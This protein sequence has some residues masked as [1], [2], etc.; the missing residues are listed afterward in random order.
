MELS[1][2]PAQWGVGQVGGC[3]SLASPQWRA[4]SPHSPGGPDFYTS[5]VSCVSKA[6]KNYPVPQYI[7]QQLSPLFTIL[8]TPPTPTIF[9]LFQGFWHTHSTLQKEKK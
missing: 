3:L 1:N 2:S 6:G 8:P 4:G 5:E 9:F 7:D